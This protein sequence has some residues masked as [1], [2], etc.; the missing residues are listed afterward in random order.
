[1]AYPNTEG[2]T[3]HNDSLT[4]I[5]KGFLELMRIKVHSHISVGS[6]TDYCQDVK[7]I[8]EEYGIST[9]VFPWEVSSTGIANQLARADA[10]LVQAQCQVG[11][12]RSSG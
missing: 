10:F 3:L 2:L 7:R 1:M 12:P 9:L 4:G 6:T 5:L 11:R 8:T